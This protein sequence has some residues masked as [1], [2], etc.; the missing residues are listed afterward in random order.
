MLNI[1]IGVIGTRSRNTQKDYIKVKNLFLEFYEEGDSICSGLCPEGGD[2]FAVI[3][4]RILR[5]PEDK[6]LWFPANWKKFGKAAGFIRNIDI[7]RNSDILIACIADNRKGGTEDTIKKFLKTNKKE[8]LF[9][10]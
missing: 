10:V 5:I 2:R 8:D 7:A 9:L 3:I 6:R 4:A 1:T